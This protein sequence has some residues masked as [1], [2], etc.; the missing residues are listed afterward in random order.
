MV[1]QQTGNDVVLE[2]NVSSWV[3]NSMDDEKQVLLREDYTKN[4]NKRRKA[5]GTPISAWSSRNETVNI[6]IDMLLFKNEDKFG[7]DVCKSSRIINHLRIQ[8]EQRRAARVSLSVYRKH[9]R[10]HSACLVRSR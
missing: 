2:L 1:A 3:D 6:N 5:T 4:I 10:E 9:Q 8:L 7:D